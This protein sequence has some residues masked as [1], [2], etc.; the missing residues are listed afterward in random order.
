V[1]SP[2][3]RFVPYTPGGAQILTPSPWLKALAAELDT[4]YSDA[5]ALSSLKVSTLVAGALPQYL[6]VGVEFNSGAGAWAEMRGGRFLINN[7]DAD[8]TDPT[9][10][11]TLQGVGVWEWLLQK[12]FLNHVAAYSLTGLN[13]IA[14][15][16]PS[17]ITSAGSTLTLSGHSF[18][19]GDQVKVTT[20]GGTVLKSGG[21]YWVVA[22][23]STTF[24]LAGS[25]G[26][27]AKSLGSHSGIALS[28]YRNRITAIGHNFV[29]GQKV[30]VTALG[31][32]NGL[33]AFQSYYIVNRTANSF[34]LAA[35]VNGTPIEMGATAGL[36]LRAAPDGDRRFNAKTPGAILKTFIDEAQARGALYGAMTSPLTYDFTATQDSNGNAWATNYTIAFTPGS[37]GLSVL[38]TLLKNNWV[39][40]STNGRVLHAYNP[41]SGT[42]RSTGGSAVTIGQTALT[43]P[44]KTS[45]DN[46][47]TSVLTVDE[48]GRERGSYASAF[49]TP[50]GQLERYDT[51]AGIPDDGTSAA[52]ATNL[53]TS[54]LNPR[55]QYAIT[56]VANAAQFL[57]GVHYFPGDKVRA[58][59]AGVPIQQAVVDVQWHL[60]NSG[61]VTIDTTLGYR[62]IEFSTRLAKIQAAFSGYRNDSGTG[63]TIQPWVN[64]I[65]PAPPATVSLSSSGVFVGT[66]QSKSQVIVTWPAVTD[67]GAGNSVAVTDYE[68]WT[69][70]DGAE[71]PVLVGR[72]GG[73]LSYAIPGNDPKSLSY[74]SVR[75]INSAG[76][77]GPLSAESELTAAAPTDVLAAPTTPTVTPNGNGASVAWDGQ[78]ITGTP[79]PQLATVTPVRGPTS[80]GPWTNVAQDLTL[81]GTLVDPNLTVGSTYWYGLIAYD[82]L[83]V[84]SAMSAVASVVIPGVDVPATAPNL[85]AFL[86]PVGTLLPG[87][88]A[89]PPAGY[90]LLDGASVSQTTY[91]A[92][93]A[94]L[95]PL[96]NT[97][98]ITIGSPGVVTTPSAHGLVVDQAVFFQTTGALPTGLSANTRYFVVAPSTSAFQVATSRGGTPINTSGTQSGVHS[99]FITQYGIGSGVFNVPNA[100]GRTLVQMSAGTTAA[101]YLGQAGGNVTRLADMGH[102]HTLSPANAQADISVSTG[103][104]NG[105]FIE[106]VPLTMRAIP[107]V[108]SFTAT[109]QSPATGAAASGSFTTGA[110]VGGQTDS[111][112]LETFP[113]IVVNYAVKY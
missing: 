55:A 71:N 90:L 65:Q 74:V 25:F 93:F 69:R 50:L 41:G 104:G 54:N 18:I 46:I 36:A 39:E 13:S 92:L 7:I 52:I 40:Y 53:G 83:G 84:A 17:G 108:R 21:T 70:P 76:A 12:S 15:Y 1:P 42:D 66:G 24:Q 63:A 35:Q 22:T 14:A 88:W 81:A 23:T 3:L 48:N 95:N 57:P 11:T 97:G 47:I 10:T 86:V 45:L 19:V 61:V 68:V 32:A 112:A 100:Q 30:T 64:T 27:N 60:D 62:F 56:E 109:H 96:V 31:G 33:T 113:F 16:A 78:L 67:D 89:T 8:D 103:S 6:E 26:G 58:R 111:E 87:I 99:V 110:G 38:Q 80:T 75:A 82:N 9:G 20:N 106:R 37:T 49:G 44:V 72:T 29:L 101:G 94:F 79:P 51:Q 59:F 107:F 2:S 43:R 73:K 98:T 5:P 102:S 85:Q 28:R 4:P 91:P 34:G 105:T 77:S